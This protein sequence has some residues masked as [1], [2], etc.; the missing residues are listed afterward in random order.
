MWLALVP[1]ND[2][3]NAGPRVGGAYWIVAVAVAGL[4][5]VAAGRRAV[6]AGA[7]Y[8]MPQVA[9]TPFTAPRGD[10]DGLWVLW[11]PLMVGFGV[12]LLLVATG[13]ARLRERGEA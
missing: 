11:I 8:A 12:V 3:T 9:L 2:P 4:V 5:R 6:A 1:H 7:A 13:A 10:D